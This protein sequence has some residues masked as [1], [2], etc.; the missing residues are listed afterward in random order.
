MD[1]DYSD[2]GKVKISMKQ[3]TKKILAEFLDP[4]EKIANSPAGDTLFHVRDS[5]DPRRRPLTEERAQTFHRTVAQLLFLVA[6]PCRDCHTAVAFLT[7]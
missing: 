4:L 5:D 7:T 6:R 1:L 2:H 3:F